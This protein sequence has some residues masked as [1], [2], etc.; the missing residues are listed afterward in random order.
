MSELYDEKNHEDFIV[1]T[2]KI[3]DSLDQIRADKN[4]KTTKAQLSALTGLHRNTFNP[5]GKR[6]WVSNE[7]NQIQEQRQRESKTASKKKKSDTQNLNDKLDKAKIEIIHWFNKSTQ[8]TQDLT[9]SSNRLRQTEN[10][11]EWY[12]KELDK[13]RKEKSL[14]EEKIAILGSFT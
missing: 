14:L 5:E 3:W 12:K 6:A 9:K 11:L 10:T 7:L 13:E 2:D 4:L 8:L 1:N